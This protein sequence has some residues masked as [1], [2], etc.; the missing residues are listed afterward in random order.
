MDTVFSIDDMSR[1]DSPGLGGDLSIEH[2]LRRVRAVVDA[3]LG[4]LHGRFGVGGGPA[5]RWPRSGQMVRALLLQ[6]LFAINHDRQLI[7]QIW[8][9]IL[10]RW[11][12][13]VRLDDPKWDRK[14]FAAYRQKMLRLSF[15]REVLLRGLAEAQH[16]GLLSREALLSRRCELAKF[17]SDVTGGVGCPGVV[18]ASR[19]AVHPEADQHPSDG[20]PVEG[21]SRRDEQQSTRD[22]PCLFQVTDTCS[23]RR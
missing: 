8:H 10:F 13:G 23:P 21:A 3:S 16:E 17:S 22:C 12:V 18:P 20:A 19:A 11:F 15:V 4:A 7:D 9:G 5:V 6:S 2:S 14:I 1:Q